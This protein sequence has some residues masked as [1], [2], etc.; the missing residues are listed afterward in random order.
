[1]ESILRLARLR[2]KEFEWQKRVAGRGLEWQQERPSTQERQKN[3]TAA[4]AE[5][6]TPKKCRFGAK[7]RYRDLHCPYK[8]PEPTEVGVRTEKQAEGREQHQNGAKEETEKR[9]EAGEKAGQPREVKEKEKDGSNYSAQGEPGGGSCVLSDMGEWEW[10]QDEPQEEVARPFMLGERLLWT[11]EWIRQQEG[12]KY[13]EEEERE[14]ETGDREGEERKKDRRPGEERE[15]E[16]RAAMEKAKREG[17]ARKRERDPEGEPQE[18]AKEKSA[19]PAKRERGEGPREQGGG[20][21]KEQDLLPPT[22][23]GTQPHKPCE[24][25]Q[26][27]SWWAAYCS[28]GASP[29]SDDREDDE[30]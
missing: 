5:T 17:N 8:H 29:G 9:Q 13:R 10:P 6:A 26:K 2:K 24:T 16:L 11:E 7:C 22:L 23:N 18:E 19:P 28:L 14:G 12:I 20:K 27:R 25:Q 4:A 30:I 21:S 1:M 3:A 15:K